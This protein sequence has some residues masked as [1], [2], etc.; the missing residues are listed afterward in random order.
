MVFSPPYC[1]IMSSP[2]KELRGFAKDEV[3][4]FLGGNYRAFIQQIIASAYIML[5]RFG[6]CVVVVKHTVSTAPKLRI[7]ETVEETMKTIGF[8][9]V[10]RHVFQLAKPSAYFELHKSRG[11]TC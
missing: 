7:P 2:K 5:R 6:W 11:H 1:N 10:E 3:R 9:N 8:K 4:T